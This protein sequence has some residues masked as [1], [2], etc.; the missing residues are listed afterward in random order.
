MQDHR[1]PA[2]VRRRITAH[3][4]MG[5]AQNSHTPGDGIVTLSVSFYLGDGAK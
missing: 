3:M 4:L 1:M 5:Y 2:V